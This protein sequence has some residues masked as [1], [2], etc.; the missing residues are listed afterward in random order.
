MTSDRIINDMIPEGWPR[1]PY[2]VACELKSLMQGMIDNGSYID[3]GVWAEGAHL[4]ACIGGVEYF[5]EI[6]R[7]L[8]NKQ[9]EV[10]P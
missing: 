10:K 3:T 6:K 4:W 8:S 1:D 2:S 5:I 9:Q 7:S